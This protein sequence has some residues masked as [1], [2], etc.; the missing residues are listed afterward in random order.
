[1]RELSPRAR[2][3]RAR[4]YGRARGG[5][6]RRPRGR[7]GRRAHARRRH[8]ELRPHGAS[9]GRLLP[10]R[11]RRLA[12]AHRD[13]RRRLELG[14][15]QRAAGEEPRRAARHPRGGGALERGAR[16]GAPQAG[17]PVRE[18]H[19]L[20]A[21]RAAGDHAAPVGAGGDRRRAA[22]GAAPR[23]LRLVRPA[24]RAGPGGGGRGRR[25]E[26]LGDEHRLGEP[27]GARDA[28]PRLLH[29]RRREGARAA[30]R[31]RGLHHA[32]AHAGRAARPGRQRGAHRGARDR[33][34]RA[35]L[36]PRAQPRPQRHLQQDDRGRAGGALAGVRLARLPGRRAP[37]RGHPGGGAAARLRAR[38]AD[39]RARGA[40]VHLA[41]VHDVQAARRLRRGA[42]GRVPAGPLRLP[43]AAARR[44]EGDGRAVEARRE[45]GG[46]RARRGR[47]EDLR[48]APLQA[49]G[50]GAHGRDGEEPARGLP[51]GDRQPGVDEPRDQGAG[52]GQAHQVHR[53]D[54]L[55]R[56]VARLRRA[57]DP[58]RRPAGQREAR[59]R[60]AVRRHGEPP[61]PA[62]GAVA[63]GDDA[64]DRERVLQPDEQRDRLPGRDPAAPLLRRGRRRRGELRRDRRGDRPRDRPRL[65]RPGAQ[66]RRRGEP[67]RLVDAGRRAGVRRAGDAARRAVRGDHAGGRHQDQPAPHD[68]R[69][70]RR[71][72]RARAGVP[73]LPDL[74]ARQ[75]G[76]GDRRLHGRP[77]LLP[78]LRADLAHEVPR[79]V[80]APAAA[81]RPALPG[82]VPRLR[83]ARQQRRV[84][85][86]VGREGGRQD[87][88]RA[89]GAGAHL[90]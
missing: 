34:R 80:A 67:P 89:R 77:A 68:G 36:G 85:E 88:P 75:A 26:E 10:L 12:R 29:A 59:Q 65:R 79:R 25:P 83:A 13:P 28:R 62:G 61:G 44:A 52:Q 39:D 86:G 54:R 4:R 73:R 41:R 15:V 78:G 84:P 66:V 23:G 3:P 55:P 72:E 53:Q 22:P 8:R 60:L 1:G 31:L 63:L 70:H 40:G 14:R 46:G 64:A 5:G 43:R 21:R 17:R 69:E 71:P 20:G 18:L 90:V 47:G 87:V 16:L 51:R 6:R 38:A 45:R 58:A 2:L 56:P 82:P 37:R 76:A 19:G 30:R 42:A 81:H 7:A 57:R 49:G 11:E 33:D 9:A 27:V 50:Q 32:A 74:A 35:A 24:G 48:G